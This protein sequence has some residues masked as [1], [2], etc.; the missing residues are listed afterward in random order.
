MAREI[1]PRPG[2]CVCVARWDRA[3]VYHNQNR[4]NA[5]A[6]G[7]TPAWRAMIARRD[8]RHADKQRP[9]RAKNKKEA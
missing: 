1:N 8:G 5:Y 6:Q 2:A 4:Y 7:D 9:K 3:I